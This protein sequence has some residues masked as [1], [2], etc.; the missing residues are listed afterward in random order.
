VND[1]QRVV[2]VIALAFA[3][4][5]IAG[6]ANAW[7]S[8]DE[9][10]GW[11]AYAPNTAPIFGPDQ[12]SH[13]VRTG[14]IWLIGVAVWAGLSLWILRSRGRGIVRLDNSGIDLYGPDR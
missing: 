10:G 9:G 3:I 5:A 14:A 2:L 13:V 6:T 4:V 11:F 8:A 1:R 12:R 7:L